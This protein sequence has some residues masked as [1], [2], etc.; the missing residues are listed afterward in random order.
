MLSLSISTE[1][2]GKAVRALAD[3]MRPLARSYRTLAWRLALAEYMAIGRT[4]P[5]GR[6]RQS[7]HRHRGTR[8]WAR[9]YRTKA[10][11]QT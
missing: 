11:W 8:D 2:F 3:A 6:P 9:R 5:D 7:G 10:T 4:R 1:A